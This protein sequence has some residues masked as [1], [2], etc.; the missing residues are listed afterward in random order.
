[1]AMGAAGV[2][3]GSVWLATVESETTESSGRR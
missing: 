2:W 3:T 1:M